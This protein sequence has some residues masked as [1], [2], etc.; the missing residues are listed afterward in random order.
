MTVALALFLST[1]QTGVNGSDSPYTTDVGEIQNALPRWGTIHWTG[2]PLYTFLG[3]TLVALLRLAGVPPAAGASLFSALWGV[4]SV[5]LLVALAQELGIPGPL[6]VLGALAAAA[7]TSFWMDS[8]LAEVHTMTTALTLAT[9]WL[10]LRFGRSGRRRELVLLALAF[11]QGVAHQ[12][13]VILLAP[14]VAVLILPRWRE[15]WHSLPA[16]LGVTLLAPLTYLYLPL[17]VWQGATWVFGSP[18]TW[19]RLLAMLLD[20]R[21]ERI[22]T[23]PAGI[24]GWVERIGTAFAVTGADLTLPLLMLGLLG[25]FLLAAERHWREAAGLTLA[26][27]PYLLLTGVIWIGHIGDAQ[28]AAHLPVTMMAAIG[29]TLLADRIAH[30]GHW[31]MAGAYTGLLVLVLFLT[32]SRRPLVLEVSRDPGAEE[33][34]AM[35]EQVAP[36]PDGHPVTFTALWGN[37]Y[38][39]L[40]YAQPFE[41]RLPGLNIVDH[42]AD[43]A[44]ILARGDRLLTF[45]RTFYQRPVSWW[46]HRLGEVHLSSAAPGIVEIRTEPLLDPTGIPSGPELDLENGLLIRSAQLEWEGDGRLRVTIYWQAGTPPPALDYS[47]AVHLVAHDPPGGP[48]DIL[49][50]ADSIHPVYGWYPTSAWSAGEIVRDHYL[51]TVPEEGTPQAVRIALYRTDSSGNFVNTPWLSLPIPDERGRGNCNEEKRI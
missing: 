5:G 35:A 25:L 18:G 39:A 33:T 36:P 50:Q 8:S 17:R 23:W 16:A 6:S 42:N 31:P 47:V 20:N 2:Y 41:G 22:V 19:Q 10:A 26:W 51:L 29:L 45:S 34:I 46:A 21:A 49:A 1:L 43:F 15:V 12:R 3:S 13:A 38:W 9:L 30:R 37:D 4:I 48:E 7:S 14:A 28:L 24:G 27:V 11:G 32:I 44:A 40:A